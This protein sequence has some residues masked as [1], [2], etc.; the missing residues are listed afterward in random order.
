MRLELLYNPFLLCER[1]AQSAE[2]RRRLRRLRGTVAAGL[3]AGHIDSLELLDALRPLEP[4]T[5]YDIGANVGTWTL[6][7]K[8][9]FPTAV[10][11]AFEPLPAQ[12]GLLEQCARRVGGITCHQTALG[13]GSY[14]ATMRVASFADASSLLPLSDTAKAHW[15]LEEAAQQE[16]SVVA[17]DDYQAR[18]HLPLPSLIKLDVQGFELSVLKGAETCL[19]HAHA[20]LTEV[21]FREF[22]HG[23]CLFEDVVAFLSQRGFVLCALAQTTTLGRPLMQ[24]DALFVHR[25]VL[26]RIAP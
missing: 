13:E 7:A 11:H 18:Q 2:T 1:L 24:A 4:T 8:A 19:A 6:L 5:I 17:L 26:G 9:I 16:V 15:R 22:Y 12:H 10:I 14:A 21:S 20:V 25:R 3:S 23:Q